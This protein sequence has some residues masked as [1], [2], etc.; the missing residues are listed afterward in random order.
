MVTRAHTRV[1]LVGF[2]FVLILGVSSADPLQKVFVL[3]TAT[4]GLLCGFTNEREWA[5]VPKDKDIEFTAVADS[6]AGVVTAVLVERFTEDTTTYDEYSVDQR[7]HV[8]RLKRTLDVVPERVTRE[9]IWNI[10]G[11]RPVKV[12]ESW[13]EFKTHKPRGPDKDLDDFVENPI[14]VRLTDFPFYALIADKHPEKWT[15]GTRCIPGNMNSLEATS[16]K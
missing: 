5:R 4:R 2:A 7:G 1:W 11:G 12:A 8:Q 10:R 14:I 9:Q 13:M 6:T 15:D 16:P 3:E